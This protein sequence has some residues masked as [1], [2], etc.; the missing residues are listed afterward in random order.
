MPDTDTVRS[1]LARANDH[2]DQAERLRT[3]AAAHM[4]QADA[5]NREAARLLSGEAAAVTLGDL[6]GD[7]R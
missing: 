1:C 7:G 5:A 2:M 4:D 6:L 3:A